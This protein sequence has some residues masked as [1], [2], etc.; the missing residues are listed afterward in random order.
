M[1]VASVLA[2]TEQFPAVRHCRARRPKD[3]TDIEAPAARE[4]I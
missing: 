2:M 1:S 3:M 4:E